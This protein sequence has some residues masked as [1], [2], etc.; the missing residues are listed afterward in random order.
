MKYKKKPVVIEA[1]EWTGYNGH[2]LIAWVKASAPE[3]NQPIFHFIRRNIEEEPNG[4]DLYELRIMTLEG[5]MVAS[6][7]DF[8]ICGVNSEFY[9]CKPDIFVKTYEPA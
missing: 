8:I 6:V 1:M 7:G 2:E 4:H 9:P 3:L 5:E